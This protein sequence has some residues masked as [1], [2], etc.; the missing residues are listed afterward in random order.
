V[1][2]RESLEDCLAPEKAKL[3]F[4]LARFHPRERK[5][6]CWA[7]FDR[8]GRESEELVEDLDCVGMLRATAPA[9][10]AG[11]TLRRPYRFP[12]QGTKLRRGA[13][14]NAATAEG[15]REV[16]I[17]EIDRRIGRATLCFPARLWNNAPD[18]L[19]LI[20][21]WPL[22]T[23]A[24]EGAIGRVFDE[25][26]AGGGSYRVVEDLLDRAPPRLSPV[27]SGPLMDAGDP[28][29]KTVRA[30][31]ALDCGVLPV[32]G[33]PGTGKTYTAARA[34]LHLVRQGRRVAV[35]SQRHEA[36]ANVLI[37]CVEALRDE[38][39]D[40]EMIDLELAHKISDESQAIPEEYRRFIANPKSNG[41][42]GEMQHDGAGAGPGRERIRRRGRRE[43]VRDP[44]ASPNRAHGGRPW[45]RGR[46]PPPAGR[47]GGGRSGCHRSSAR[48][49][50]GSPRRYRRPARA[51]RA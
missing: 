10:R 36:V 49:R 40:I 43:R 9:E 11:K 3:L 23:R 2:L 14:A 19:D 25:I 44:R 24:I 51:R 12:E 4:D 30:V 26:C 29:E 28:V 7:V 18:R 34:I 22:D 47:G 15:P 21:G 33:P 46:D 27:P 32:Q 13:R 5:P 42:A 20:P 50:P 37:A 8:I 45:R 48:R 35:A 17:E 6:A 39:G 1:A 31:A 38:D 41:E 16:M